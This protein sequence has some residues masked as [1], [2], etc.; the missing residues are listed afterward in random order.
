MNS[1]DIYRLAVCFA[2]ISGA[3]DYDTVFT[4]LSTYL[5]L[6]FQTACS[7]YSAALF[8][9]PNNSLSAQPSIMTWFLIPRQP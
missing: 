7:F 6:S 3:F 2:A 1:Q 5:K 8:K 9:L 4:L